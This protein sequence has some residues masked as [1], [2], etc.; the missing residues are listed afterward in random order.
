MN[1]FLDLLNSSPQKTQDS[2]PASQHQVVWNDDI[3]R[4]GS[5]D[6]EES[7]EESDT[8]FRLQ[9]SALYPNESS[10]PPE[11]KVRPLRF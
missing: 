2:F 9:L 3:A 11:K 5:T 7:I 10:S 4:D 6:E 1:D 8:S